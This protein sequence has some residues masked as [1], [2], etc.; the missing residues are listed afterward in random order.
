[1]VS[2]IRI[3]APYRR[4]GVNIIRSPGRIDTFQHL[5]FFTNLRYEPQILAKIGLKS[6]SGNSLNPKLCHALTITDSSNANKMWCLSQ[7]G[8]FFCASPLTLTPPPARLSVWEEFIRLKTRQNDE[9][10][11]QRIA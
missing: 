7:T 4:M 9:Y 6:T 3:I 8:A 10:C 1:M 2:N 11:P 5:L